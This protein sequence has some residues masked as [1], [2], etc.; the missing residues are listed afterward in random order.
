MG[1]RSRGLP[2]QNVFEEQEL[3]SKCLAPLWGPGVLEQEASQEALLLTSEETEAHG[4]KLKLSFMKIVY[5]SNSKVFC[6]V[7]CP[8]SVNSVSC[9]TTN[10]SH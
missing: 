9:Y 5:K 8:A 3:C 4:E 2:K 10:K 7:E 1:D 6:S